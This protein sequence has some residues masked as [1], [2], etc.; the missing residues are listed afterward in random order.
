[1]KLQ[2]KNDGNTLTNQE[3][4]RVKELDANKDRLLTS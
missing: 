1:M 4:K 2:S 3:A